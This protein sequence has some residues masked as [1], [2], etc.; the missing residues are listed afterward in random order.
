MGFSRKEDNEIEAMHTMASSLI[1]IK[2]RNSQMRII[3]CICERL[4]FEITIKDINQ[5]RF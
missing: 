5:F 3:K 1:P 2:D 4:G